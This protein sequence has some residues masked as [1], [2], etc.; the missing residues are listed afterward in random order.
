MKECKNTKQES[1][2][3]IIGIIVPVLLIFL[4]FTGIVYWLV[5]LPQDSEAQTHEIQDLEVQSSL[6]QYF[7]PQ[8][9][10]SDSLTIPVE[11]EIIKINGGSIK[12][13]M[14][15]DFGNF[16]ES[17]IKYNVYA[18]NAKDTVFAEVFVGRTGLL[19]NLVDADGN[20]KPYSSEDLNQFT[21][22]STNEEGLFYIIEDEDTGVEYVIDVGM[23]SYFVR[24]TLKDTSMESEL[25]PYT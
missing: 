3:Q 5:I 21:V 4:I 12:E 16:Y 13:P 17:K 23:N 24:G 8:A 15:D 20:D 11:Q 6:V 22:I 25:I 10:Y 18:D 9:E 14:K 2:S 19:I 7:N 1:A